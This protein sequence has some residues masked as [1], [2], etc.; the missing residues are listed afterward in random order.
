M[1]RLEIFVAALALVGGGCRA[2]NRSQE[3]SEVPTPPVATAAA[4]D[5]VAAG[6]M[7]EGSEKA[8]GL[9]IP[10]RMRVTARFS[11]EVFAVGP[12]TAEQLA[13]YVRQ[14]VVASRVETGAAKTVF[15]DV[16]VK[17]AP[18]TPLRIE[19]YASLSGESELF[20]QD[21][22]RPQAPEGLSPEDRWKSVGLTPEGKPLDP[23]HLR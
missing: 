11:D 23:T 4:V 6:E 10:R 13:N 3:R 21:Q 1:T 19:V 17:G 9:P 7:A 20:V 14:R 22:T 2:K 5:Q 8:F 12:L 15:A 16:T 18:Q